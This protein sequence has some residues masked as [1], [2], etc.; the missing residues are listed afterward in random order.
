MC[1]IPESWR[2][3][4]HAT[5]LFVVRG[6]EILLIHKKRGLGAGKLN[7]AEGKIE[8]GESTLEAAVRELQE[9]LEARPVASRK[10]GEVAFEVLSGMSIL[11]HVYR[12]DGLEGE[13]VETSEASAVWPPVDDIP[14]D[15][16]WED[17]R[18]WPPHVIEDCPFE[19]YARFDGDNIVHCR[20]VLFSDT[21][22]LP[23]TIA[24]KHPR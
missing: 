5:L 17:D 20:V 3:D 23:W 4:L 8:P 16:M 7:G 2:P 18:R 22:R 13:P 24:P 12:A 19:V 21:A 6:G 11:I 9:E 14:Y 1:P 10:V 15:R